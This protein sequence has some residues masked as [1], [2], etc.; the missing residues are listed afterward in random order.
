MVTP[1]VYEKR[2]IVKPEHLDDLNHV[3]NVQYLQWIQDIAKAHWEKKAKSEWLEDFVW[4]AL[5][6]QIEYKKP[7]FLRDKL[8]IQ[9][10]VHQFTGVKSHRFT[11]I[12]NLETGQLLTQ[13]A[14]WWCMLNRES[15]K[16]SRVKQE[17]IDY[18]N[19]IE[20]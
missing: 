8:L 11:R 19:S 4:V 17:M 14:T 12:S 20:H 15:G 13:S 10:H 3:N 7:A 9:T 5:S 2:I 1:E 18:F 16:P 6:H